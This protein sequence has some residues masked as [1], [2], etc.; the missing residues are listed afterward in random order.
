ME[1][2][3]ASLEGFLA[4]RLIPLDKNPGLQ[5]IGIGELSRCIAGKV[6]VTHFQTEI[7]TLV[8]SLQI[9]VGHEAGYESIACDI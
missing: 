6:V 7:V 3:L 8:G 1:N 5:P 2:Q 4:Y 9:F